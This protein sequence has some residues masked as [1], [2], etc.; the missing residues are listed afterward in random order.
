MMTDVFGSLKKPVTITITGEMGSGKAMIAGIIAARLN[1]LG[2][3]VSFDVKM[4]NEKIE[5]AKTKWV[6]DTLETIAKKT[7]DGTL[8]LTEKKVSLVIGQDPR[9][10]D[11]DKV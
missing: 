2:A 3:D 11:G 4:D 7:Q 5:A 9:S 8:H 1:E 6:A 10:Q